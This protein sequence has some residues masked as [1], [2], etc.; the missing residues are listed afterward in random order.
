MITLSAAEIATVS[1][2]F[3]EAAYNAGVETGAGTGET[4]VKGGKV[5]AALY[6]IVMFML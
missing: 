4:L 6:A 5:I 2:G 3:D 1:G